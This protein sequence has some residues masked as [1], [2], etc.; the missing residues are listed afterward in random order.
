MS[1]PCIIY[2]SSVSGN[3]ERFVQKLG[4]AAQRLPLRVS[5]PKVEATAP[6][7]LITPTYGGGSRARAVPKQ[8]IRFLNEP[9]NRALLRGVI[10][11]GNTNFGEAF[12]CAGPIIAAKCGV[13]ELYRFE[14]LGTTR[15]VERV[16]AGLID[17]FRDL[18]ADVS[19]QCPD[20][21]KKP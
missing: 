12:C 17:F 13:P 10:T 1:E 15:D 9:G 21:A 14:L 5:D 4:F 20:T 2:F 16:R 6:Y 11:S 8:V 18:C 19:A 7:V 3:T